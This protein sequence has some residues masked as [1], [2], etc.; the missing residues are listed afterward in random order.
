MEEEKYLVIVDGQDK[1]IEILSCEPIGKNLR[2]TYKK[3]TQKPFN[4]PLDRAIMLESPSMIEIE[5]NQTVYIQNMRTIGVKRVMDFQSHVRLVF[6]DNSRQVHVAKGLEIKKKEASTNSIEHTVRY[7]QTIAEELRLPDSHDEEQSFL[8]KQMRHLNSINQDSP[9]FTYLSQSKVSSRSTEEYESIFPFR[10]NLS[11]YEAVRQAL[12]SSISVIEGPPGTGKTQTILNILANL[13]INNKSVAVVSSNNAAVQNVKEKLEAAGYGFLVASLGNLKNQKRFF[14]ALP[15]VSLDAYQELAEQEDINYL[16][17]QLLEISVQIRQL[18]GLENECTLLK[19]KVEAYRLEYKHFQNYFEKQDIE[20]IGKLSFY[21]Q[22]S[23]TALKFL[24]ES[25]ISSNGQKSDSWIRKVKLVLFHGFTN[26]KKL[27]Q[28]E[29]DILLEY[30]LAFYKLKIEELD[31]K[32]T[33]I[34]QRLKAGNFEN[35]TN[36]HQKISEKIFK[37]LIMKKY[38]KH[39]RVKEELKKYKQNLNRF[40]KTYPIVLSTA[41]SLLSCTSPNFLFDYV[42][43]DESS[44]VNLLEG[45]LA[46]SCC[47]RAIIVGDTRQLPQIVDRKLEQK[48]A[49]I[50]EKVNPAFRY[51]DHSL[52]TSV[53]EIYAE[54]VPKTMLREHYRCH[55][56]IIEFCNVKYYSGELIAFTESKE[57]VPL[58]I[59]RTVRGNHMREV[60]KG[61]DLGKFNRRELDVI[62]KEVL[63]DLDHAVR[64]NTDLGFVTPYRKQADHA[65]EQFDEEIECDT[66]HKYQG[67]EKG[68][69]IMSTVIDK[70]RQGNMGLK[71]VNDPRML[72]VAVSRAQNKFILVTGHSMFLE[73]RSEVG[74]LIRYM[75]YNTMD[76]HI[77]ESEI[78]SVFDLL[79]KDYSDKLNSLESRVHGKS[80]Y[81]TEKIMNTLLSEILVEDQYHI[82]EYTEQIYL[83]NLFQNTEKLTK[84][85]QRYIKNRASV[86]FVIYHKLDKKPL[87]AIEVDGFA[88]HDNN[89]SQLLKDKM[90][91]HIFE[92]YGLTLKR[93]KTNEICDEASIREVLNRAFGTYEMKKGET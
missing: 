24:V 50:G 31:R 17:K 48:F 53:L 58:L 10:F 37:I 43:I 9:L 66:V 75:E 77:V 39:E 46:L 19:Q 36:E 60:T 5:E 69:M 2:I 56:R 23:E 73:K 84:D 33:E 8:R 61:E 6:E 25:K 34:S 78:V 41:Q 68:T 30:Q 89:P 29:M 28:N 59:Y 90:K 88:S 42:I 26:F 93:Y 15:N 83:K 64:K 62:E 44:Q 92:H 55:P 20:Q 38:E 57:D 51:F 13:V 14:D 21:Q 52:L 18:M 80:R 7:W 91:D 11:Q 71:F 72:N 79:Y 67:R 54:S 63:V 85:E 12:K 35:L 45:A 47:K 65:T 40:V 1:T 81:K 82:M 86:D 76:E 4:Y 27:K 22:T 87:L 16:N 70:T 32:I 3:N 74:D 49:E